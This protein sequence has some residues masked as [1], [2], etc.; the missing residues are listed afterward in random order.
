MNAIQFP[1]ISQGIAI[2]GSEYCSGYI[3]SV[4]KWN[5]GFYCPGSGSGSGEEAGDVFCCGTEHHKYC[6]TSRELGAAR[7]GV[8][9]QEVEGVTVMIGVMVGAATAILLLIIVLCVCCPW[10]CGPANNKNKDIESKGFNSNVGNNVGNI[11]IIEENSNSMKH[12]PVSNQN[13][14]FGAG[15]E[16]PPAYHEHYRDTLHHEL[17]C[18]ETLSRGPQPVRPGELLWAEEYQK[19]TKF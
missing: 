1:G 15:Q 18:H 3:D 2:L 13:I 16:L 5:T 14:L 6:C 10:P 4:G 7:D 12:L 8:E 11:H 9:V 17:L 19:S